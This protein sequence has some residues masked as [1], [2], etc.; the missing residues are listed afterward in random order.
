MK[1]LPFLPALR[2]EFLC[3]LLLLGFLLPA[4]GQ[5]APVLGNIS[6]RLEVRTGE[7]VLIGGFIVTG[8]QPKRVI[9]RGIGS[10]LNVNGAPLPG[11]LANPSLTLNGPGGQIATNDDWRSTQEA[12][13]IASMVPPT[14][15][16]ESAIVATLP[17]SASGIGYT[18]VLRGA[19]NTTGIGLVEV[20]D[21]DRAADSKLANVST[22]GNVQTGDNVMIG[23]VIVIGSGMQR[24]IVRAIGPSLGGVTPRVAAPLA[25]PTLQL[26]DSN[27]AILAMNDNWRSTQEAEIIA[28]LVPPTNDLESAIVANLPASPAGIG[29]TAVVRGAN[30]GTGVA[31]VEVFG[32]APAATAATPRLIIANGGDATV[33]NSSITTANLDGSGGRSLGN[34]GGLLNTPQGIAIDATNGRF[35]AGNESGNTVTRA[36]LDG[37]GA[38]NLTLGGL[39]N[40]PYGVALDVAGN[41]MYVANGGN[42]TV[43]RADL[44]GSNAT[45][46]GN[47]GGFL[48]IPQ[49]MA[50]NVAAGK[51]YVTSQNGT[52]TQANLDGTGAVSLNFNGQLTGTVPLDVAVTAAANR[53]YVVDFNGN[54]FSADLNGGAPMNLGN[55]NGTLMAPRGMGLDIV[56][57]K[58]Y[59]SNSGN[60]TVT[61]ADL[62]DGAN[63]VVLNI[64]T[65]NAPAVVGVFRAP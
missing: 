37:T 33:A 20:F 22:R 44:D 64:A 9:V 24:V 15:D 56:G 51:M 3:L 52:I 47:P 10:S 31:L 50:L 2:T 7:D 1:S 21:L 6:T 53:I 42:N 23:G 40:G 28:T 12:E 17:A 30:N 45:S 19:N 49:G 62:P 54:L 25:D 57:R 59:I 65:L 29:Y 32:L 16:L 11:R 55:L 5:T 4:R 46:L 61:R 27:G 58:M 26:I 63:P 34:L 43:V 18:A 14:S 48:N 60:N 13:I 8:T 35:Y 41:K 36:N 38:T 39:L